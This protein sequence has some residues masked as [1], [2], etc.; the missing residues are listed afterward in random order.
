MYEALKQTVP[1]THPNKPASILVSCLKK[2]K[3]RHRM[4]RRPQYTHKI[5]WRTYVEW[6]EWLL[7]CCESTVYHLI[8]H[9]R[10]LPLQS[11]NKYLPARRTHSQRSSNKLR[12]LATGNNFEDLKF[13][14]ATSQS[15]GIF[16]AGDEF[17]D[18]QRETVI[19]YH[20]VLSIGCS[21]VAQNYWPVR[22]VKSR[23]M[24]LAGHVSRMG[25]ERV[26]HRV[27]VAKPE[28]KGP[29]GRPRRRWEDNIKMDLQAVG[30]GCRDWIESAQ[31]RDR[32]RALVST[33]K[34]LRFP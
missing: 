18:R 6:A 33:V 14:R 5:S 27:L 28:E 31:D 16:L 10:L 11:L 32:W 2:E 21:Y 17:T 13:L 30:L 34:N 24:R 12:Y 20:A 15:T 19:E 29:L 25:E 26:V 9:S 7:F 4:K 1:C 3:N 8:G 22:V 23:R